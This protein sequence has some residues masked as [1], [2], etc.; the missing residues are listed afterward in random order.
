MLGIDSAQW[1]TAREAAT[2]L[3]VTADTVKSYLRD[4]KLKGE[5]AGPKRQ[6]RVRGAEVI[7]L[8]KEWKLDESL[9]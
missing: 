1:Y 4:G 3:D 2:F 9:A 7:R 5:Q 6:W 8:L